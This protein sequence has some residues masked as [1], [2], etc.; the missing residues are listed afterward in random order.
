MVTQTDCFRIH[1]K[2]LKYFGIWADQNDQFLYYK[3]YSR[4]FVFFFIIFYDFLLTVNLI[5]MEKQM[6]HIVEEAI[7]YFT[8]ISIV[9]KTFTFLILPD[10]IAKILSMLNE[11]IFK[12]KNEIERSI[13]VKAMKMNEF[14]W[15][16]FAGFSV[17]SNLSHA[18]V[19]FI[20]HVF[21]G[22]ELFL[23]VCSYDFLTEETIQRY[24]YPI[25]F[26]QI[27]GIHINMWYNVNIDS[28]FL[29][30]MNLAI[31]Q[32]DILNDKLRKVTDITPS[33]DEEAVRNSEE[34]VYLNIK[35]CFIH[36]GEVVNFCSQVQDTFS[37]TLFIQFNIA[38]YV[39][40][41]C[42]FRLTLPLTPEY[43]VF[44]ASYV[45][46][47]ISQILIPCW[48]G[49]QISDKSAMLIRAAYACGWPSCP[50]RFK[51][52]LRIFVERVSQP[53]SITGGKIFPLMLT[54]FTSIA[55]S[56]YSFYTL[57]CNVQN[58]A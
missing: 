49:H 56:A 26:Y 43:F 39:L 52:S 54:T 31:A 57:L 44:L 14:C 23:P 40:C 42:L 8:M 35:Q 3:T 34:Q 5:F 17:T 19:P 15:K 32:V 45:L 2:F 36:Y 38:S 6:D 55:N 10:D 12:P 1:L 7:L 33:E 53:I 51:T 30:L 24:I 41:V 9:S 48:F 29:G 4:I 16:M 18:L 21:L 27:I 25:Y 20:L 58:D 13:V 37:V 50:H 47:M 22:Q 28:F 46:I 11:D